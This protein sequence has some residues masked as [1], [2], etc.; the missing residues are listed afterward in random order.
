MY[1]TVQISQIWGLFD[2][3]VLVTLCE[4]DPPNVRH[5]F[6]RTYGPHVSNGPDFTD[7]RV[8]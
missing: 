8:V 3:F 7:I 4:C 1:R 2:N 5:R 6:S